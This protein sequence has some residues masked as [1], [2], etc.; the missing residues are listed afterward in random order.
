MTW[1]PDEKAWMAF[2]RFEERMGEKECQRSVMF[3]YM[4]AFPKL[5]TYLKV[6]KFEVKCKNRESARGIYERTIEELG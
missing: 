6:A 2:V 5:R 3:R 1:R 4:E